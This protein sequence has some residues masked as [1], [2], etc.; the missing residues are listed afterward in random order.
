MISHTNS[1]KVDS[2]V[3][4]NE[5]FVKV[6]DYD[7]T[8]ID[9]QYMHNGEIYTLPSAPSHT[10]LVFQEWSSSETITNNQIVID[11]NNVMIG[12]VYT[13]SSGQ[14]EF[15]IELTK[16]TG[17]SVTLRMT[18]TKDWG[19]GTTNTNTTHTYGNYGN[20]TIKC[21]GTIESTDSSGGIFNQTTGNNNYFLKH[22]RLTGVTSIGS[23]CAFIS[24]KNLVSITISKNITTIGATTFKECFSL[25]SII[26]PNNVTI[27]NTNTFQDCRSIINAVIPKGVTKLGS[28]SFYY[29]YSL[30]NIAIPNTVTELGYSS[31]ES[32]NT[33]KTIIIPNSVTVMGSYSFR[34]CYSLTKVIL[35]NSINAIKDYNFRECYALTNLIMTNNINTIA[36]YA[37]I[38][39]SSIIKYD[40]SKNTSVPTLSNINAFTNING[41]C[42][43]KVPFDLYSAWINATNWSTYADYIDGGTP[44]IINFNIISGN[45][46]IYFNDE[47]ITNYNFNWWGSNI[48]YYAYDS[49]SNTLLPSVTIT[50][51]EPGSTQNI[52]IDL[53]SSSTIT[54]STGTSGLN[55][56]FFIDGKNFNAIENNGNYY[57]NIV[58]NGIAIDYYIDGGN[59]YFDEEGTIITTGSNITENIT[60]RAATTSTFNRP[61]LTENGTLGGSSFAVS[62][63]AY[64]TSTNY[65]AWRAVDSNTTT[66]Y[67]WY[68]KSSGNRE[69]IFYNPNVIKV[70][71]LT[72][73]YTSSTYRG[74]A[75]TIQGSNDNINWINIEST[76]SGS[77]TTYTST[78]TNPKYYKYYKLKFTV[79]TSYIRLYDMLITATVK[80]AV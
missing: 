19:D 31:F 16:V 4:I 5:Y 28:E 68:S 29:C 24:C 33:L 18:G 17:V 60:M 14:C 1:N 43:I 34:Y 80:T 25:K 30:I 76:Y 50:G 56:K 36:A 65:Q 74:T 67:Y 75:V 52:N 73:K 35:S 72:Y 46:D 47:L 9:Q 48:S 40:F 69:Y 3:I 71:K 2:D 45:P 51:I 42:K 59:N 12:A 55:V 61:N 58:G 23:Y 32:C 77:S 13:T 6:V 38:S 63:E 79:Y 53:S 27:I 62:A 64:S 7:G 54:L 44:A 20:Y 66:S 37:F 39:C 41:I 21:N 78:I 15:D 57:I 22:A 10:G 70:T 26:I 49:S 8:I 11:N